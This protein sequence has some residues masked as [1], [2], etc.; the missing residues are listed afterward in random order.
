[1]LQ[2]A[3]GCSSEGRSD[4]QCVADGAGGRVVGAVPTPARI[5][6]DSSQSCTFGEVLI[7]TNHQRKGRKVKNRGWGWGQFKNFTFKP[8]DLAFQTPVVDVII[9]LTFASFLVL[10]WV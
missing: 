3:P 2:V 7:F 9:A 1:M 8:A 4:C 5:H 6:C 10:G